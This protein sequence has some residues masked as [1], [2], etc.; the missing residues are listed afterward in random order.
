MFV[1]CEK[2]GSDMKL[3]KNPRTVKGDM[4]LRLSQERN[5]NDEHFSLMVNSKKLHITR[6]TAS[7]IDFNNIHTHFIKGIWEK[8]LV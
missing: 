7:V 8:T 6:R 3:N 4:M 1:E 2:T 5:D